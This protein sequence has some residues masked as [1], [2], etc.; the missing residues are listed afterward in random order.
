MAENKKKENILLNLGLN[1]VAPVLIMTK[2]SGNEYLGP[3]NGLIIALIFPVL[4]GI[5][6][7]IIR[8][9]VNFVSILGFVSILLTGTFGL[10]ELNADWFAIKEA[11]VPLL[12][13]VFVIVSVNTSY[14]LVKKLLYND[15][16]LNVPLIQARLE[17]FNKINDFNVLFKRSS[18]YLSIAF[19]V[20]SIL[21]FA[22]AKIILKSPPGSEQFTKEIGKMTGLSFPVIALPSSIIMI[23]VLLY[24]LKSLKKMT[25]LSFE[26]LMKK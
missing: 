10:F 18:Y 11:S 4:Y 26:E 25:N 9:N 13:G 17:E 16:F 5:Y 21:N 14:P 19:F 20:S 23:I 22:L 12:I 2:L 15:Q 8:K 24:M 7:F 1:I 3:V 6:D